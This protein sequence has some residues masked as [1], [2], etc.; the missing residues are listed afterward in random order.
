MPILWP[1]VAPTVS[2][3]VLTLAHVLHSCSETGA[4]DAIELHLRLGVLASFSDVL[5]D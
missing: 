4:T 5:V 3:V 1:I 2:L